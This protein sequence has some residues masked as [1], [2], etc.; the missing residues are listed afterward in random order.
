[1]TAAQRRPYL[2]FLLVLLSK[3][4]LLLAAVPLLVAQIAW[5]AIEVTQDA[6]KVTINLDGQLFTEYHYTG[7]PHVYFYPVIGPG[8][9][10]MTRNYPMQDLPEEEHDHF[11]HRSLWFAHGLVN[12]VDF[13]SELKSKYPIG[14]IE[15]E[16]FLELKG[17]EK[18]GVVSSSNRWV[19]PDGSVPLTSIQT[20][21]VYERPSSERLFD[22]EVTLKAAD[23]DVVM[24]DTKDGGMAIRLAETMRLMKPKKQPGDG[25][26]VNS[27]GVRDGEVW[28][29]R[30]KWVDYSG[31][32]DGK[33]LGVAIFEN[34]RNATAP[35][36]WHAREYG[37][38]AANPF[39]NHDMDKTAPEDS[40]TYTIPAGQSITLRYRF[41][42]HEGD[43]DQAK[44]ADRYREYL[45][46]VK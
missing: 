12:G 37:L 5:G 22:F 25:H 19:A 35:T 8:G 43:A 36:R 44:I 38:F 26:L 2:P 6:E 4:R 40:G 45:L 14:K 23:K 11:H 33:I 9:A 27:E 31:P 32:V 16:K 29:K 17:S 46:D 34:P 10:K 7:A 3:S 24:G 18:E 15:H 30:A 28:S 42:I 1:L 41:L 21:R 39:C 13:W 20:F